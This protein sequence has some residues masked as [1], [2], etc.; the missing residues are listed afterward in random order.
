MLTY[1]WGGLVGPADIC[2]CRGKPDT[3]KPPKTI[4]HFSVKKKKRGVYDFYPEL[5]FWYNPEYDYGYN[6][7][8]YFGYNSIMREHLE[9]KQHFL[10][11]V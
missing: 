10:V 8:L 6:L 3:S 2:S 11:R 9:E 5:Y 1:H 4:I 7:W